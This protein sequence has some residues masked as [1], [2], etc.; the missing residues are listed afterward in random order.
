MSDREKILN[1]EIDQLF[2]K[3]KELSTEFDAIYHKINKDH[4]SCAEKNHDS[5]WVPEEYQKTLAR[6]Q[7]SRLQNSQKSMALREELLIEW[8]RNDPTNP[9]I[10]QY[11]LLMG[12]LQNKLDDME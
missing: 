5:C 10:P 12:K 7:K 9:A 11:E 4:E 6:I 3:N 1:Y 2:L 8:K